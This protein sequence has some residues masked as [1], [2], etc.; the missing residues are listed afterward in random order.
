MKFGLRTPSLK[1]RIS[2]RTSLKRVVRHRM[3][4]KVPR[5]MGMLTNPKK[6]IYNKVYRKT[7]FG[8]EG[9]ARAGKSS[10]RKLRQEVTQSVQIA[11]GSPVLD[12]HFE[13]S[14]NIPAL[15]KKREPEGLERTIK[16]CMQQIDLA[17][18][19]KAVF[20]EQYPEQ[21]LPSHRGYKQLT[22]ILDKQS[23]YDEAIKI[24][25]QAK[26]E[27]WAGDWGRRIERYNKKLL[28]KQ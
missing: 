28:I 9:I 25:E 10:K 11:T 23:R 17:P 6:A 5:G 4:I 7:T 16:V 22:I 13:L 19:A 26:Y 24:C 18:Q 2:A 15:Y 27:G 12:K 8:I 20:L 1:K 14:E 3:G 21:P